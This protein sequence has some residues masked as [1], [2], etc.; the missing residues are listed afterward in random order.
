[1]SRASRTK[2]SVFAIAAVTAVLAVA[3]VVIFGVI[4]IEQ[5]VKAGTQPSV[6]GVKLGVNINDGAVSILGATDKPL[7]RGERARIAPLCVVEV[8]DIAQSSLGSDEDG[9]GAE[10]TLRWRLW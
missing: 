5:T 1:M 7:T 10:V 8:I 9:A 3:V 6:C 2:K 4:G